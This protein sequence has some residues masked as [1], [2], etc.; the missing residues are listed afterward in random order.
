LTVLFVILFTT[1]LLFLLLF[2]FCSWYYSWF[3]SWFCFWFC[4]WCCNQFCN[5]FRDLYFNIYTNIVTYRK[6]ESDQYRRFFFRNC[7]ISQDYKL[8]SKHFQE[9]FITSEKTLWRVVWS[10]RKTIKNKSCKWI[11]L[12][13]QTENWSTNFNYDKYEWTSN[14]SHKLTR[15]I[16][17]VIF[18]IKKSSNLFDFLNAYILEIKRF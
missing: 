11:M 6:A 12:S 17:K 5:Q 3:C 18:K 2:E 14:I 7:H 10:R 16:W 1:W 13:D 4:S 9:S 8:T 15:E